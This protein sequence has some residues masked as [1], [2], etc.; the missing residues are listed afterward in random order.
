MREK[1]CIDA[2]ESDSFGLT[3]ILLHIIVLSTFLVLLH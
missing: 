1:S 3:Q 2:C